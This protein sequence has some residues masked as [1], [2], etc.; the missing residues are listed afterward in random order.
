MLLS[1]TLA[2]VKSTTSTPGPAAPSAPFTAIAITAPYTC[3]G[4]TCTATGTT[5]QLFQHLKTFLRDA[6]NKVNA[7]P[8]AFSWRNP[9]AS[10]MRLTYNPV[11]NN[12]IDPATVDAF[13][14]LG[15]HDTR[16]AVIDQAVNATWLAAN[17]GPVLNTLATWLGVPVPAIQ[18]CPTGQELTSQGCVPVCPAGTTRTIH[19]CSRNEDLTPTTTLV[20]GTLPSGTITA[21]SKKRGM[22]RVAVP[23][24][25][26][27][28][29]G[30]ATYQEVTPSATMPEGAMQTT[31]TDLERRTGQLPFYKNWIFWAASVGGLVVVSSGVYMW[32]R[33]KRIAAPV[34]GRR[35]RRR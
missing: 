15:R 18:L 33:R 34:A 4:T 6:V 10:S 14:Y 22:W 11:I 31:E 25:A 32:K 2:P 3:S 19:G 26:T 7:K 23:L 21:F 5:G 17:A 1:S 9:M 20:P 24:T 29:A 35:R 8:Q 12:Q 27:G 13:I 16:F 30:M 28:L